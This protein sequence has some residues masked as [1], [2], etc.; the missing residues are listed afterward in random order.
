MEFDKLVLTIYINGK[1]SK[2]RQAPLEKKNNMKG[3]SL[4]ENEKYYEAIVVK[5]DDIGVGKHNRQWNRIERLETDP[6]V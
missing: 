2:I 5:T 6:V 3:F 1:G 4:P